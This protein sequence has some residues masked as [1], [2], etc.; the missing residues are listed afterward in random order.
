[1]PRK[2]TSVE[3]IKEVLNKMDCDAWKSLKEYL[4]HDKTTAS[5]KLLKIADYDDD[6]NKN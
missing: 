6:I 4:K 5:T 2:A 3:N 1:M